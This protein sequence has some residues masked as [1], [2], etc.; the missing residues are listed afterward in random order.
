MVSGQSAVA[1]FHVTPNIFRGRIIASYILS[2]TLLGF[3]VGSTL[4]AAITDYVFHNDKAVGISFGIVSAGAAFL[5]ALC[6]HSA[7]RSKELNLD[8]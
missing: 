8:W 6:L 2:G 1:L 7:S 5:G 4:I 3:G